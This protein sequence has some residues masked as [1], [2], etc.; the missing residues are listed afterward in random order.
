MGYRYGLINERP[1]ARL[2][3]LRGYDPTTPGTFT[4]TA[5][6]KDG[7]TILSGQ[8]IVLEDVSGTPSWVL[9][10]IAD[11]NATHAEQK[12]FIALQD[13]TD[14]DVIEAEGLTGYDTA[15]NFEFESAFFK[16][17][18]TYDVIENGVLTVH[19]SIAGALRVYDPDTNPGIP[20]VGRISRPS[21]QDI[22][23]TPLSTGEYNPKANSNVRIATSSE[24]A[25]Y[26]GLARQVIVWTTGYD[27]NNAPA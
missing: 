27:R 21:P 17:D 5:P 10:V 22:S 15:G 6:V 23:P 8:A 19:T 20:T 18:D 7:V 12:I 16:G 9:A 4:Q 25:A 24:L 2:E 3:V 1:F 13:S 11:A 26:G 14:E